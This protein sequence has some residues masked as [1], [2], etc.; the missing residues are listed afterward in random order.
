MKKQKA[1]SKEC[2]PFSP[3]TEGMTKAVEKFNEEKY[4]FM[5]ILPTGEIAKMKLESGV[6]VEIENYGDAKQW[7][8]KAIDK[9]AA[10]TPD[11]T[12]YLDEGSMAHIELAALRMAEAAAMGSIKAAKELFDRVLGKPKQYSENTNVSMTLDDVLKQME[13]D[14]IDV[15]PRED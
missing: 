1:H 11:Q 12:A 4:Y 14:T 6:P 9:A 8:Q 10:M 2:D 13:E 7:F 15:T 5:D 3:V